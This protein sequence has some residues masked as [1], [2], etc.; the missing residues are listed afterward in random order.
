[1][2]A[3]RDIDRVG[4]SEV[5]TIAA[6]TAIFLALVAFLQWRTAHQKAVLDLFERRHSIYETVRKGVGMMI[7]NSNG[8]DQACEAE[9]A[10]AMGRA[11][12]FFGDDVVGYL[13]QLWK[14]ITDVREADTVLRDRSAHAA[15]GATAEKSRKAMN[16]I[17]AFYTEGR[18]LWVRF[19]PMQSRF[20]AH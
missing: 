19:K 16:R 20:G 7:R 2:P 9:F 18:P 5:S 3:R 12:F 8:F 4:L 17:T 10:Q 15:L 14:A 1:M 11:Y 6:V 13:E